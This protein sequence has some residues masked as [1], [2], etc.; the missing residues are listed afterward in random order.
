ML[1]YLFILLSAGILFS[2]KSKKPNLKDDEAVEIED[3]IEF[4]PEIALPF[5]IS[6]SGLFKKQSASAIIGYKVFTQFIPDSV[7][8]KDFGKST[9]K[10]VLYSLG[11]AKEK[12]RETY[13][14]VNAVQAK[15]RIAYLICF[16]KENN[17]LNSFPLVKAGIGNY[18]SAYG[19]LD[20][21]YQITTY[22]ETKKPTGETWYKRNV[23]V[24]NSGANDFTLILT[25]PN[26]EMIANIINPID[27]LPKK[28]KLSG[29]YVRNKQNFISIRDGKN[30]SEI[31][32]FVHFE[33]DDAECTGELK[34]SARM[35]S[36]TKAH[37]KENGNPCTIEFTFS[38]SSA[39]VMKEIEGCG[40]YRDIKCFFEGRFVRKKEPKPKPPKNKK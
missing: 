8:N 6:D 9:S 24:Y 28:N 26:E 1:K 27:T 19:L 38:G 32:F 21:K 16:D 13:L 34:G 7:L 29:D 36:A 17:Y 39:I 5:K 15:K 18:S 20:K 25:E 33:K 37:Y 12:G 11:R 3:F 22:Q 10:P 4:F 31:L 40:S 30:A 2:C 14:F 23:Y 35:V